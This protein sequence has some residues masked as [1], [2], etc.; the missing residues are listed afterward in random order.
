MI[1]TGSYV[2]VCSNG[3]NYDMVY[4]EQ[5][6]MHWYQKAA[7]QGHSAAKQRLHKCLTTLDSTTIS[8][9][10]HSYNITSDSGPQHPFTGRRHSA[11]N[12][13]TTKVNKIESIKDQLKRLAISGLGM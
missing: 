13:T 11:E 3:I 1:C 10:T 5:E 2:I 7:A 4:S 6:A 9:H 12:P 8:T